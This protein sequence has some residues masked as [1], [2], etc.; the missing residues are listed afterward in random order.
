MALGA[1]RKDV[2]G[3][4]DGGAVR[5][6]HRQWPV[7]AIVAVQRQHGKLRRVACRRTGYS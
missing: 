5:A 7:A 1:W 6:G 3:G 4:A 2:A